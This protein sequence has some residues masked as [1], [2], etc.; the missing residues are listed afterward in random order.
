MAEAL[1]GRE[2]LIQTSP[3]EIEYYAA[4]QWVASLDE[5]VGDKLAAEFPA[6]EDARY[7][8]DLSATIKNFEQVEAGGS[9]EAYARIEIDARLEEKGAQRGT[10]LGRIEKTYEARVPLTAG[11]GLRGLAEGLSRCVEKIAAELA[12]DVAGL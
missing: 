11:D 6:P 1:S 9:V 2:L 3:T 7:V 4:A 5:L 10:V 12:A 8:L